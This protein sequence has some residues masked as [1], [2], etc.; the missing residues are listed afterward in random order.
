MENYTSQIRI[1]PELRAAAREQLKGKWGVAVL[2][3]I[4]PSLIG[5]LLGA[6]PYAG[7]IIS[8]LISG[9][10]ALGVA[11]C[12]LKIIRKEDVKIEN[13]FDGFKNFKTSFLAQLLIGIFIFLWSLLLVIPGIIASLSYSL[14]YYIIADEPELGAL[15]AIKKS[16]EMMKGYKWNLFLLYLSFIGWGILSLLT[17]GIGFLWLGPYVNASFANFYEDLKNARNPKVSAIEGVN[18]KLIQESYEQKD[19]QNDEA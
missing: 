12:F 1:N 13:L 11:M 2:I 7:V 4:L 18:E 10:L 19:E 14:T 3:T 17:L 16:K 8:I 15:E 6:I 9:P 5:G